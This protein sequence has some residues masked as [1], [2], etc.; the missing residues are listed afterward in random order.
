MKQTSK[1]KLISIIIPVYNEEKNISL[2]HDEII[3]VWQGVKDEY[4]Y[5]V[6]FVDDGSED[7]SVN[8]LEELASKNKQIKYLQFSRNFGKEIATSAGI[9][10]AKGDAVIML[11]AD[12]QHPPELIPEFI[13]KWENNAEVVIGVRKN[14]KGGALLKGLALF[15]FI[16][17]LILFPRQKLFQDLLIT[18]CWTKW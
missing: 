8:I 12:L 11:D 7:N 15:S 10:N 14:N 17:S 6:I 13:K 2:I 4:N 9:N 16:K 3:K 18:G 5:E 1:Q